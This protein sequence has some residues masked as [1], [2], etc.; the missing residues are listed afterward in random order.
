MKRVLLLTTATGYQTRS[1]GEAARALGVELVFGLDRCRGLEDP[2][3]DRSLV[4][5]YYDDDRSLAD[6]RVGRGRADRSPA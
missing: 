4:V 3:G 6:D 1:F 2:W 5:R